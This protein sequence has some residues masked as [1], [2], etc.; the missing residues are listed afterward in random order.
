MKVRDCRVTKPRE[1]F[2]DGVD[3]SL[4]RETVENERTGESF[5]V[6]TIRVSADWIMTFRD[7]YLTSVYRGEDVD[8]DGYIAHDAREL[9]T[10]V[11]SATV[12]EA[13]AAHEEALSEHGR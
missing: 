2:F 10:G 4:R 9:G 7:S 6:V 1:P 8:A 3:R 5:L 13:R 11:R 12:E